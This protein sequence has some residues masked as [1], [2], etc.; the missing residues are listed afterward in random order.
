[1]RVYLFRR[2]E[3][4]KTPARRLNRG[5]KTLKIGSKLLLLRPILNNDY[6]N[7]EFFSP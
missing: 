5:G 3:F 7:N 4:T 6:S 1:M 2:S